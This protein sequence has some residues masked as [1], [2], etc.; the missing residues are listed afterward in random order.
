MIL[1]LWIVSEGDN[2]HKMPITRDAILKSASS[3]I[4]KPVLYKYNNKQDDF[5]AHEVDEIACGV[6]A[7]N[8]ADYFFK[9]D[10]DGK[11]WL[12]CRA[13]VWKMYYP[14]IIDV[15]SR[16]KEKAIS[17]EIL[18]V[19]LSTEESGGTQSIETFSFT[20]VTLLG[21]DYRPAIKNAKAIVKQFSEMVKETEK[22]LYSNKFQTETIQEKEVEEVTNIPEFNK[23]EFAKGYNY[24]VFEMLNEFEKQCS[25]TY[26]CKEYGEEYECKKY[27]CRDFCKNFVYVSDFEAGKVCAVPYSKDLK[28]DFEG[29]KECRMTYVVDEDMPEGEETEDKEEVAYSLVFT[30]AEANEQLNKLYEVNKG[31]VEA[32]ENLKNESAKFSSELATTQE[33]LEALKADNKNLATFKENILEQERQ[34]SIKFAI[35]SVSNVLNKDQIKEWSD[36]AGEYENVDSFKNAIQ[37]FAFSVS[38]QI[39]DNSPQGT[40]IHIPNNEPIENTNKGLWD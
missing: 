23:V 30:K 13:Y 17:M 4:G 28:M 33:E 6:M 20:G 29:M 27:A 11:L 32:N 40:R 9:E 15:F 38:N 2:A 19:D 37:A 22:F 21:N 25:A 39:N 3:I 7:L 8:N 5:M 31:L 34:Q 24:T 16:D 12:V 1:E 10:D 35:D 14:E 18:I 26:K 36:K